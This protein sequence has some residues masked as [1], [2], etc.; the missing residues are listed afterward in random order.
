MSA[1]P[2]ADHDIRNRNDQ[3]SRVEARLFIPGSSGRVSHKYVVRG[4]GLVTASHRL[5][6]RT[7]ITSPT[8]IG[9][10]WSFVTSTR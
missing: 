4:Y 5:F 7:P 6:T 2:R 1:S 10:V 8:P 9:H 3:R